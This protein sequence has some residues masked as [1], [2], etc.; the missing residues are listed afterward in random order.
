MKFRE[1]IH[2]KNIQQHYKLVFQFTLEILMKRQSYNFK[3][4]LT[5]C[6]ILLFGNSTYVNAHGTIEV[7]TSRVYNCRLE[8]PEN[9]LS[10]ACIAAVAIGGTQPLYDWN[11]INQGNAAGNHQAVIPDGTLCAGGRDKYQGLNQGR[12]DWIAE[13][14]NYNL[15]GEI[16]FV[17]FATA[18]HASA[19]FRFYVTKD[20]YDLNS[21]LGW[22]DLDPVFCEI[23]QVTLE[24][25]RYNMTC[26]SPVAKTGKHII[27]NIWQRADSDEA[28]YACIDVDFGNGNDLI[29]DND[30]ETD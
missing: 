8:N 21:A 17:Y 1:V 23:N 29:F 9:P 2:R 22:G 7:P 10:A 25:Q 30:F 5:L 28:F 15:K 19:Y 24:N 27:Y 26:P 12:D 16:D 14:I 13:P 11:E 4:H 18:P 3:T 6:T 20:D